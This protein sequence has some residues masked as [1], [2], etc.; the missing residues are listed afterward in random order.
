MAGA[1][2]LLMHDEF[3]GRPRCSADL[4]RGG[5][6]GAELAELVIAGRLGVADGRVHPLDADA[7]RRPARRRIRHGVR[8]RPAPPPHR[9]NLDGEP[10]RAVEEMVVTE[11][12]ED[13]V[14]RR[15]TRGFGRLR[16]ERCPAL[17]LL[18]AAAPRARIERMLTAPRELD[19]AGAFTIAMMWALGIETVLDARAERGGV[20]LVERIRARMPAALRGVARRRRQLVGGLL[21][22]GPAL[23]LQPD[24]NPW[25]GPGQPAVDD[26]LA[27]SLFVLESAVLVGVGGG[28]VCGMRWPRNALAIAYCGSER[29]DEAADLLREVVKRCAERLG[30][31]DPDTLVA[32]G[33][34]GVALA[35]MG[36]LAEALTVL[37][38]VVAARERVLG[39]EHVDTLTARD[40]LAVTQRLAGQVARRWA[41][42]AR[43]RAT[44]P[45]AGPRI[46]TP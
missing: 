27:G 24:V 28:G 36:R 23:A 16:T 2:L 46:R 22:H 13:G 29:Y 35:W 41:A 5:L 21:A 14:I 33:N 1:F 17:D 37:S 12:V 45:A 44:H 4:L 19:L 42:H 11:L 15:E 38:N 9:A 20:D 40:A 25:T 10:R 34:L 39:D 26:P 18:R 3:S 43:G 8:S 7:R 31:D 32:V 30:P 6:V